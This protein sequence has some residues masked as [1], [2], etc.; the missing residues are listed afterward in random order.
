MIRYLILV[1]LV[2][3]CS[4]T[5]QPEDLPPSFY[6][7]DAA[8]ENE[9]EKSAWLGVELSLLQSEDVFS[10]DVQPGVLVDRV[11]PESPAAIGGIQVGD[12]ILS[13]DG[14]P[15]DDPQRIQS[16][17]SSEVDERHV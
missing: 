8:A 10:L 7:I 5:V 2:A 13:Y 3:S 4:F 6:G 15:T 12:I 17:L 16:L 11:A 14:H 1:L 9:I